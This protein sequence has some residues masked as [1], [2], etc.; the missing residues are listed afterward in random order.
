MIDRRRLVA[1][2]RKVVL[3]AGTQVLTTQ[4]NRIDTSTL[5]HLVEQTAGLV[6][7]RNMQVLIVTSG[8]VAAG[9][10]VLGWDERPSNLSL[11]QAAASVGQSRIMRVYERLFREQGIAVGQVL[12][13]A[14][15]FRSE[16]RIQNV[17]RTL[18]TLLAHGV[19]PVI[20][21]NDAV[22]V[23]ELRSAP[24]ARPAGAVRF[25]DNDRL[26]ARVAELIHADLLVI[27][28]DVDGLYDR[29]PKRP[30]AR[31]I[32]EVRQVDR[33]L[34]RVGS[35]GGTSLLGTGGMRTKLEAAAY[36]NAL[37]IPCIIANGKSPWILR[38]IFDGES[39]GTACLPTGRAGARRRACPGRTR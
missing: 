34:L 15:I 35:K 37:G 21:E 1:H 22:A 11:L 17:T 32:Q 18:S 4:H 14:D 16:E 6:R 25:G 30:G 36:V 39:V 20:N 12:L 27:L 9:M 29:D 5:E 24:G 8:A 19:I 13:T 2:V 23:D 28:S 31:L 10:Q 7:S 26:S 33:N 3:K 38:R